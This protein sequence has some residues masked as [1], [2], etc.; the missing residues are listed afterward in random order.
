MSAS[1]TGRESIDKW[2]LQQK[3]Q[4]RLD[5][6]VYAE[7]HTRHYKPGCGIVICL[8]TVFP[9]VQHLDL[10]DT[11]T[12]VCPWV[13]SVPMNWLAGFR[14][15]KHINF[16]DISSLRTVGNGW[17]YGCTTL[18]SVNFTGLSSLTTVG[19]MWLAGCLSLASVS[20][21]GLHS[22]TRVGNRWMNGCGR[23]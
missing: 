14:T 7:L 10:I 15:W 18:E 2:I 17:M 11:V 13:E 12:F 19:D 6:R 23:G 5:Q 3:I 16:A 8:E 1:I 20:F 21:E 9:E 22:L 4:S